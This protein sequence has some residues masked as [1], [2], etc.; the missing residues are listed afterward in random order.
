MYID[1][2][3][4]RGAK[5]TI[6]LRRSFRKDGKV[7]K[8]TIANLNEITED[9]ARAIQII[10]RGEK[11]VK[12]DDLDL[13]LGLEILHSAAHGHVK[14]VLLALERLQIDKL[15]GEVNDKDRNLKLVKAMIICDVL[16]LEPRHALIRDYADTT[17]GQ[18]LG[19]ENVEEKELHAAMD[20]LYQ[21]QPDIEKRLAER[22]LL[23]SNQIITS[24]SSCYLDNLE[25]NFRLIADDQGCPVSVY[26]YP[27]TKLVN[28]K[29]FKDHLGKLLD[30]PDLKS[31][32][33]VGDRVKIPQKMIDKLIESKDINWIAGMDTGSMLDLLNGT[34]L[35][36]D[37]LF[38]SYDLAEIPHVN[39]PEEKFIVWRNPDRKRLR[40]DERDALVNSIIKFLD[41]IKELVNQGKLRKATLIKRRIDRV[42]RGHGLK[43]YFSIKIAD[44]KFDYVVDRELL[45]AQESQDGVFV[46]RTS[47]IKGFSP[48]EIKRMYKR[49]LTSMTKK[50][51]SYIET[52]NPRTHP[53]FTYDEKEVNK[54]LFIRLLAT[55]V[56]WRMIRSW[57]LLGMR[58]EHGSQP[59][60]Q[61]PEPTEAKKPQRKRVRKQGLMPQED[62]S[63]HNFRSLLQHLATIRQ[64]TCR[65]CDEGTDAS[66]FIVESKLNSSQ[67]KVFDLLNKIRV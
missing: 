24:L 21:R 42:F 2:V 64:N 67:Q 60:D 18:S 59:G 43:E 35:S 3:P 61:D 57:Q 66:T 49:I 31:V 28:I 45:D 8:E 54:Y 16:E 19:L 34:N 53:I 6:L 27:G 4:N 17:L 37:S 14:A 63:A 56:K 39:Y 9:Q 7:N 36:F 46:I 29:T 50:D 52:I 30:A 62:W 23:K 12:Q 51:F 1:I 10:L 40:K 13:K 58:I 32:I 15:L 11:L 47:L 26:A 33:L 41:E 55:Y 22:H 38:D 65:K 25:V 20:W 48:V 5:P 44:R